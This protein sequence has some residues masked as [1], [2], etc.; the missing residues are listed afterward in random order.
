MQVWMGILMGVL[1]LVMAYF[2]WIASTNT[3]EAVE[4]LTEISTVVKANTE[5]IRRT[6]MT[7]SA[8]SQSV[9]AVTDDTKTAVDE[10]DKVSKAVHV[11]TTKIVAILHGREY[12][13]FERHFGEVVKERNVKTRLDYLTTLKEEVEKSD[14]YR[15]DFDRT[16]EL[17]GQVMAEIE[18]TEDA[19]QPRLPPFVDERICF[20]ARCSRWIMP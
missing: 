7:S 10:I 18:K 12:G 14:S 17:L 15:D 13:D 16:R 1:G 19:G 9:K 6:M 20:D 2:G 4:S 8:I 3:D 5:D 11:N